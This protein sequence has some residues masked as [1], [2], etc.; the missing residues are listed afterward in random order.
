MDSGDIAH[1][2]G[3][4]LDTDNDKILLVEELQSDLF[5]SMQE[6]NTK[7]YVSPEKFE[8]VE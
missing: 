6:R 8:K 1:L 7:R 5:T 2:R 4:I 3:S